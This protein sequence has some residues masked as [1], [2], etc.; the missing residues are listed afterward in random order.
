MPKMVKGTQIPV[1]V[2]DES[3]EAFE[4]DGWKVCDPDYKPAED[5]KEKLTEAE[6]KQ[7]LAAV[8]KVVRKKGKDAGLTK[9]E[10]E[11]DVAAAVSKAEIELHS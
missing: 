4:A 3:V 9:D 6:I 2:S 10:I 7:E 11:A 5:E 1:D 8:E